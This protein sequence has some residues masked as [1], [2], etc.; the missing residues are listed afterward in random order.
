MKTDTRTGEDTENRH[1]VVSHASSYLVLQNTFQSVLVFDR[2][3]SEKRIAKQCGSKVSFILNPPGADGPCDLRNPAVNPANLKQWPICS[4]RNRSRG[5]G[6]VLGMTPGY[7]GTPLFPLA[8][9]LLP[10]T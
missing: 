1:L 9:I 8:Y 4:R 10:P 7:G 5:V 2:A 3:L 6:G